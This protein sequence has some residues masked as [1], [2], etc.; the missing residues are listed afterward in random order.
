[1][2]LKRRNLGL[3]MS[4]EVLSVF[5]VWN[6]I[7]TSA[8]IDGEITGLKIKPLIEKLL[9]QL[10]QARSET[11]HLQGCISELDEKTRNNIGLT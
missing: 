11:E 1:M 9:L 7:E 6:C 2:E 4:G 8:N 3:V 5:N 10:L